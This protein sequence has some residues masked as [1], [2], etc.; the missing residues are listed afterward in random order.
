MPSVGKKRQLVTRSTRHRQIS[1]EWQLLQMF[2][3]LINNRPKLN[4]TLIQTLTLTWRFGYHRNCRGNE[5]AMWRVDRYPKCWGHS[6]THKT[7]PPCQRYCAI[8]T[9][10]EFKYRI[11]KF[12]WQRCLKDRAFRLVYYSTHKSLERMFTPLLCSNIL[13]LKNGGATN[14]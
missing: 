10:S 8:W 5:L 3:M 6:T 7:M 12:F 13:Y 4:L 11:W 14:V 9:Q 2:Y 1:E